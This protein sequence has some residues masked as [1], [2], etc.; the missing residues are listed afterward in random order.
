M[1]PAFLGGVCGGML[2][3]LI[4]ASHSGVYWLKTLVIGALDPS[5]VA[6]FVIIMPIKG[7]GLAGPTFFINGERYDGALDLK[8]LLN[9][10]TFQST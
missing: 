10:L 8:N 6:R 9:S 1:H 5:L 3:A 7:M 4:A 2:W